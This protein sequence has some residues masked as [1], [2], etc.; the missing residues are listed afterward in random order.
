MKILVAGIG[1]IF[2][3]DDAFGVEVVQRLSAMPLP[4]EVTVADFGIRS[5]DLAYAMMDGYDVTI[6]LDATPQGQPPGTVSLI[7]PDAVGLGASEGETIDAH[8][9]NPVHVLRMVSSLGGHPGRLYLI[10]CE[11]GILEADAGRLG[12]SAP[13]EAAVPH[14]IEMLRTLLH[15]LLNDNQTADHALVEGG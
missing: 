15:E 3:G 11:P 2:L 12:L 8:S 13:V 5:Y 7:E 9:M 10:G 6:L 1:N 4:P 14:A